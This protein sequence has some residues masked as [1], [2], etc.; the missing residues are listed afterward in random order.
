MLIT[1]EDNMIA[2]S[3]DLE[4]A[5]K[6]GKKK[7]YRR[8]K[9]PAYHP[10]K[11][12]DLYHTYMTMHRFPGHSTWRVQHHGR[13]PKKLERAVAFLREMV[14]RDDKVERHIVEIH[15]LTG[16]IKKSDLPN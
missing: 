3:P 15:S 16:E 6:P 8:K 14:E 9:D 5:K 7:P 2:T 13:G 1:H 12:P 4:K 11:T 10:T